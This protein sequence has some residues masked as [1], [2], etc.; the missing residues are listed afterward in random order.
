MNQPSP[1]VAQTLLSLQ[2]QDAA[3]AV[4]IV[5]LLDKLEAAKDRRRAVRNA[6]EGARIAQQIM[7][8]A[9]QAVQAQAPADEPA[10][11]PAE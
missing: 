8:E 10:E 9:A 2:Q 6:L 4:E 7:V 11:A 5:E 1:T 3:L